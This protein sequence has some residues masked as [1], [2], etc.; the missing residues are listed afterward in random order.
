M[1]AIIF[2]VVYKIDTSLKEENRAYVPVHECLI[3]MVKCRS[4]NKDK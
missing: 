1:S 4:G 3:I 2:A